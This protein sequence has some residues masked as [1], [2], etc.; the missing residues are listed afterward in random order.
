M[1][2]GK[3]NAVIINNETSSI[4]PTVLDAGQIIIKNE[5]N[6]PSN[7]N[8][9]SDINICNDNNNFGKMLLSGSETIVPDK[10]EQNAMTLKL[11]L[12]DDKTKL[13]VCFTQ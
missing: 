6:C 4:T 10:H 12:N 8:T 9:A 5:R 7:E 13:E 2:P 11:K 3:V 1:T